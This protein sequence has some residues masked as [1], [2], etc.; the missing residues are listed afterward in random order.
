M[1]RG[2]R[3]GAWFDIVGFRRTAKRASLLLASWFLS[4]AVA[5]HSGVVGASAPAS[6]CFRFRRKTRLGDPEGTTT[7]DGTVWHTAHTY[8]CSA[9]GGFY[10]VLLGRRGEIK[11]RHN[12]N[13][14]TTSLIRPLSFTL[15]LVFSPRRPTKQHDV[16]SP[17]R[18]SSA[19]TKSG[20][21]AHSFWWLVHPGVLDVRGR[22]DFSRFDSR[23]ERPH[24]SNFGPPAAPT[25]ATLL[26]AWIEDL[27][28]EAPV[29]AGWGPRRTL[30]HRGPSD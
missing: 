10:V 24:F 26:A 13:G 28:A 5:V 22:S 14:L 8:S 29:G 15:C 23:P 21:S 6:R 11:T 20:S 19:G 30:A 3:R 9:A 1:V 2:V 7:A 12:D 16:E 4:R 27:F 17:A 25:L 18:A